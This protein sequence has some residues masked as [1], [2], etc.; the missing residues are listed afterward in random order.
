WRPV[1]DFSRGAKALPGSASAL[2]DRLHSRGRRMRRS[3][4]TGLQGKRRHGRLPDRSPGSL[5]ARRA[6]YES[7]PDGVAP[8]LRNGRPPVAGPGTAEMAVLSAR[9]RAKA[10]PT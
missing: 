2:L 7:T 3:R 5:L 1:G 6:D 8:N 9:V 10:K 4:T